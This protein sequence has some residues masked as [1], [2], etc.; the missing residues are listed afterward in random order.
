MPVYT[1][2]LFGRPSYVKALVDAN[3]AKPTQLS[4]AVLVERDET[5]LLSFPEPMPGF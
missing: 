3:I 5:Q 4:N 1:A 2:M